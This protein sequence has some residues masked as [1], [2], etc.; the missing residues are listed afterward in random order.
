MIIVLKNLWKRYNNI[1]FLLLIVGV[2]VF[3]HFY[4]MG[5]VSFSYDE[6]YDSQ[7]T[8]CFGKLDDF[9]HC[10][11]S[12]SQVPVPFFIHV[13]LRKILVYFFQN[14]IDYIISFAFGL[15]NLL[16]FYYFVK[17]EFNKIIAK[18]YALLAVTS[19]P[20][21]AS[22]RMIF[23]HSNVIFITFTILSIVCFYY[24]IKLNKFKFLIYSSIFWG[25]SVGSSLLGVFTIFFFLIYYLLVNYPKNIKWKHLIFIPL[26]IIC[27]FLV[28][29]I[30]FNI[31]NLFWMFKESL[32]ISRFDY[33]NYMNLNTNQAPYWYSFLLFVVKISPWWALFFLYYIFSFIKS[34]KNSK[35]APQIFLF[36]IVIFSFLY[37]I[38]KSVIFR[39]DAP[40]HQIH[41][42]P[43]VY[44]VISFSIYDL[45]IKFRTNKLYK[46]IYLGIVILFFLL[47]IIFLI[48]YFPNYLF[49]GS[50]YGK[51]FVGEFYGP[52]VL[53]CQ[54]LNPINQKLQEIA[55]NEEVLTPSDTCFFDY[56]NLVPYNK[57]DI[58]KKY[59]YALFDYLNIHLNTKNKGDYQD[60]LKENCQ[61]IYVYNFPIN[62]EVYTIYKCY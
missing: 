22:S 9:W 35:T 31:V 3:L 1:F 55:N 17:R 41:L 42:S 38:I 23:S 50:F 29:I 45:Y 5:T 18:I 48:L 61:K 16:F 32:T 26:A 39:Y 37:F 53:I 52:A 36:N 58:N 43:F 40:H 4:K 57:R 12:P 59:K 6:M 20:L 33:W 24:F 27:F 21:L 13:F 46:V 60:F 30:Y 15:F 11:I 62:F 7:I 51:N 34:D 28:T 54:D 44:L 8:D 2:F 14:N 19:I 47:Q 10:N 25:I 56:K 49:Y